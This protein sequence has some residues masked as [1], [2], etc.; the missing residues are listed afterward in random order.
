MIFKHYIWDFDGTLFDTYPVMVSTFI[1]LLKEYGFT[2]SYD[3]VFKLM[4]ESV[5][6]AVNYSR[7]KFNLNDD[8]FKKFNI[9]LKETEKDNIKPFDGIINLC[10]EIVTNNGKNY[11]VTH[12]RNSVY[13]FLDKFKILDCF[14][15][16][17]CKKNNFPK[18]PDPQSINYLLNKY[19]INPNDSVMIGDRDIDILAGKNAGI[20]TLYFT[21]GDLNLDI[22]EYNINNFSEMFDTLNITR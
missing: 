8:F 7:E 9:Y 1:D 22:A 19:S 16:I 11:L 17:I 13:Y 15:E 2:E 21:N 14:S 12:R 4:K 18:K 10:N 5:T 6:C 3:K 20:H